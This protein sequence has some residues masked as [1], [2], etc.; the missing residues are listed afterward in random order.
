[1]ASVISTKTS[2]GG[3]I[4][5]TGDTSGVLQLA[6]NNG[7]TAVTIDA[8]QNVGI[9]TASPT[10]KLQVYT[11]AGSGGQIQI[12]NSATGATSTDGV[13]IGYDGSNDVIINNQ[14]NT[15]LKL[16]TSGIL[17]ASINS[18]G[19]LSFNSGY[20]SVASAYG[21]RAWISF[22]G[23]G[24][25]A[26]RGSGNVSSIVDNGTGQYTINLATAMP[27]TNFCT[28]ASGGNT[29]DGSDT[30]ANAVFINSS[31]IKMRAHNSGAV[32]QDPTTMSCAVFR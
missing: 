29:P 22:N 20:G 15:Q 2:G 13:L 6:S 19:A 17:A 8:S 27:D 24:T 11:S 3:G 7:T 31:S 4:A 32:Q 28:V 16:Y 23:S 14:E 10:Q 1:M 18:S 5:F 26:I 12:T 9:G 21:C 25:I 30:I